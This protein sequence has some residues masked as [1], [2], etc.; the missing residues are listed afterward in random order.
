[1]SAASPYISRIA[2]TRRVMAEKKLPAL[3]VTD[4]VNLGWLS[5]FSGS[6]GFGL[7]TPGKA[8][9][10]TDSRY[11]EQAS[12]QCVD[13]QI[14]KLATSSPDEVIEL[15]KKVGASAIGFESDNLT[16]HLFQTYREK[17]PREIELVSTSGLIRALRM[18]KDADEV[19]RIE[20][21]VEIADRTWDHILPYLKPGAVERDVM[22]EL[23]WFIRGTCGAEVAFDIIVA[24]GPRSALPHGRAS[25]RAMQP[26]EF[27]TLDFGAQ[28]DGYNSD[29]TRT[30]VLR[31]PTAEQ[32]KVYGVVRDALYGSIEVIRPGVAGKF[33]DSVGREIIKNA[34]YGDYFG[35]GVGHQLGRAVHDGVAFSVRSETTVQEGMVVTVEPG[36]YIP[37]WG[38]VRIEHD[39]LVTATGTRVLD[40]SPTELLSL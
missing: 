33:V 15:L 12:H 17:L 11:T 35:H 13:F 39:V 27:V 28:L 5:G 36:V 26:G 38:G 1:M 34:G 3:L 4:L 6:N 2:A 19:R 29:I 8:I 25:D 32:H 18:I 9:F 7:L 23:E 21:A 24:S 22:L 31:E 30:V 20:A 40:K 10:A 14:E 16:V 37:G